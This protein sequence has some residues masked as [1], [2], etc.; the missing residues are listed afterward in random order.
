MKTITIDGIEYELKEKPKC[1]PLKEEFRVGDWIIYNKN[2]SCIYSISDYNGSDIFHTRDTNG[3][4]QVITEPD[5]VKRWT[6]KDAKDG[7]VLFSTVSTFIYAGLDK[8]KK[9]GA[10]DDTI[11]YHITI[12]G[13][14]RELKLNEGIGVG[15]A[16]DKTVRPATAEER[17]LL[18]LTLS[19]YGYEW[20]TK[21]KELKKIVKRNCANCPFNETI[22]L[23]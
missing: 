14:S 7:D 4:L 11:V 12:T 15:A 1:K 6:I 9:Y 13:S 22:A 16:Y 3:I 21:T 2:A 18:F 10:G 19:C 5:K 8:E 20:D 23:K 17:E